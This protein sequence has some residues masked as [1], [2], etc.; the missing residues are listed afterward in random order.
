MAVGLRAAHRRV[1]FGLRPDD[2][3]VFVGLGNLN[4][5]PRR[6]EVAERW[7][8]E[9]LK[10]R[11]DDVNVRTDLGLTYF[12]RQPSDIESAIGEFRRS[13]ERDPEHELTLQNLVVALKRKG[14]EREARATLERLEKL[15]PNNN[16][17]PM[18]REQLEG[19]G[20][21]AAQPSSK[22]GS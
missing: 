16:A 21:G 13:L 6:F 19:G 7:Y 9:A 8:R 11:P 2:Y 12:L 10:K 15:N 17:L 4:Y 18:L 14:D 1:P 20:G 3:G 22:G 5:E